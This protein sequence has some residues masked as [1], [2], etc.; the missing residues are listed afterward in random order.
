MVFTNAWYLSCLRWVV[1]V[2]SRSLQNVNL[3]KCRLFFV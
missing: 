2:K 1:V 3:M